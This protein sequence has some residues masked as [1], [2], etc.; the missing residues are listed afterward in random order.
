MTFTK[1]EKVDPVGDDEWILTDEAAVRLK[2]HQETVREM[3]RNGRLRGLK[4]G[5]RIQHHWLVSKEHV[6]ALEAE[7]LAGATQ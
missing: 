2:V 6:D 7:L 4:L 5:P 3:L 1:A